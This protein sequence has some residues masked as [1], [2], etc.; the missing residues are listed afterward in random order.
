MH[1]HSNASDGESSPTELVRSAQVA[2]LSAVAL[3]DHDTLAGIAEATLAAGTALR[4]VC[5]CE[6]SVAAPWGEMH[7]LG[8][9]LP[10]DEP[11]LERFLETQRARRLARGE[12]I[13]RR[14]GQLGLTLAFD[15]VAADARGA[16]L[17]R[18]HIAR[19]LVTRGLVR[20][21]STAFEQYLGAGRP[22]FVPKILPSV[23]E[24]SAL[25][26]SVGGVSAAAHLKERGTRTTLRAL[27]D[28]GVDAVEVLHPA[29]DDSTRRRI[30]RAARDVG[31]LPTGGSDWHGDAASGDD[32]TLLGV[33]DVPAEWLAGVEALHLRR[34]G[35]Q[36]A[37]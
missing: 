2:R 3:T 9:F 36:V 33:M 32:R 18:P 12:E 6:F 27:R 29:H 1:V 10:A 30:R 28:A 13:V 16:A 4:V 26:R 22:A 7:L 11:L 19:A 8:Y 24:V 17:G 5:G 20:D 35:S 21:V 34:A 31:M 25:I 23:A 15:D 14:L 37:A